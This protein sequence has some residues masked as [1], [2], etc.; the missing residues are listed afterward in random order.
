[1]YTIFANNISFRL[2]ALFVSLVP[3]YLF[4][5]NKAV[6]PRL[7]NTTISGSQVFTDDA[8]ATAAIMGVYSSMVSSSYFANGDITIDAGLSSDE[9]INFSLSEAQPQFYSNN[10]QATNTNL[11][12]MWAGIYNTVY[13]TNAIIE[14]LNTS[15]TVSSHIKNQLLGEAKFI[16]AFCYFYLANLWHRPPLILSTNYQLNAIISNSDSATIYEQIKADLLDAKDLLGSDFSNS[17]GERTRPNKY[18]ALALLSRVYLY[19]HDWSNAQSTATEIISSE[20]FSLQVS[21]D[22]VFL[23]NSTEAIWQLAP[24]E[25]NINTREGN[26]FVLTGKPRSVALNPLLVNNFESNDQRLSHWVG[27]ITSGGNTYYYPYKYKIKSNIAVTEYYMIF[28]VAEQ[29]LIRA[30]A[31][32]QQ[33]NIAGS[34]A[35]INM[36]RARA[37][38]NQVGYTDKPGIIAAVMQERRTEL[39]SEWGHRWM[40]LNRTG[41]SDALLEIVKYPNWQP[42]DAFYPIPQ[43]EIQNNSRLTQNPGY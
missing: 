11:L 10:I 8:T 33:N 20:L 7:S 38:L 4:S 18:A 12:R 32:A 9:L 29:Y 27:S 21:L 3:G 43:T 36:I 13:Q 31:M 42:T 24:V 37:G 19:L 16:R 39:F 25:R 41:S 17:A 30:E 14:G 22:D 15:I 40:D 5:C 35:D 1:M 28:R 34:L 26:I 2:Y 6:A 23:I